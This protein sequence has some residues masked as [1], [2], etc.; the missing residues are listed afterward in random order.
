MSR[1]TSPSFP[2][3][4]TAL[5][6]LSPL[7]TQ[8]QHPSIFLLDKDDEEINP[9]LG[10]NDNKP[11][12]TVTTCGVC[13]DYDE[14]TAGYHFQM[15]WDVVAD[16]FG[17]AEGWPWQ[18][19]DGMM[20]KWCLMYLRQLAKKE[21]NSPD[22]IDLTVYDFVGFSSGSGSRLPCGACHPGGGG[23]EY[24]RSGNRYDEMLAENPEL[25]ESLDGDYYQSNWDKSGVVEA[26]CFVCHLEGYD[27]DERSAQLS[28]GN[29]RWAV[30]AGSRLGIV[31]GAVKRGQEPEVIYNRRFFN[32]DGSITLDI[33]WPPP[34]DN[35]VFCHGQSDV[36]KRGFSWNDI[37]NPDVHNGQG[38]SCTACHPSGP[39]HQF[40]K[41]N[42]RDL[43]VADHLD[44]TIK[45]CRE[46]HSSGYMGATIPRHFKIRPSHLDRISCEACH[47]PSLGRAAAAGFEAT[48][49]RLSFYYNPPHASEFGEQAAWEPAYE[50]WEEE[51]IYPFNSMLLIWWGNL[52]ADSI[53]YPLW[54]KEHAEGWKL[55]ADQ[56]TDDNDD[57]RPEVNRPE[58]MKAGLKAFARSLEGNARFNQVHP[59]LIKAGRAF[60]LNENDDLKELDYT[61]PP[62]VNFS[63]SHN[64]APARLALGANGCKDCHAEEAHFFKG[65]RVI[66]LFDSTGVP[67]TRSNGRYYGCNPA[68]FAINTF[69][70]QVLSPLVST[71]IIIA[72]FLITLHYHSYGPKHIPFVPGSGE[73]PRF[74]L[75]ERSIH[76]TRLVSFIFLA[77]TGLIMAFNW[78]A[79]QELLFSSPRQM[80]DFHIWC[81]VTFIIST[82]LGIGMWWK[83]A[84]FTG[85]DKDWVRKMGG[86]L[87]HKGEIPAGRFNAGQKMFY[88][89]SAITG[90]IMSITGL[91]LIYKLLFPLSLIC[92]TSTVHN[93]VGFILIAG[94][95]S[96]AYLGTIANPG[97]WRVL[98]DGFVTRVWARHHHPNWYRMLIE[99]E[100]ITPE[101]GEK[102]RVETEDGN[103]RPTE[104]DSDKN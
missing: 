71:A 6:C 25:R 97:T 53:V 99:R 17:G 58:E 19:S 57:G 79:W 7:V 33:S 80:Y 3:F 31:E 70:Q 91:I 60:H 101:L 44:G 64:V 72:L 30:V 104:T 26:D 96:H 89:Y 54:L 94:V 55:F 5:L 16:D 37:H 51:R 14:I 83:D 29:Y 90:V 38:I 35:C 40:T 76:L 2:W 1:Q 98:V 13:H 9:I 78:H 20:G 45:T 10:E 34:D 28:K 103:D 86:Y 52:E 32:E 82:V 62:C 77:V 68:V 59:V 27:F 42:A 15:G 21:N 11:F 85:Y 36:R 75:I 39:D 87:G 12:S 92:L 49:G 88:W 61:S 50:R 56:V 4:F 102:I 67:V 100:V 95:L 48:S 65:Q 18:I 84:M 41:G 23:L 69:H 47:I 66:D 46:C 63:I 81:G 22:E 73:V 74:S 24:D 93:L 43:K 8:A